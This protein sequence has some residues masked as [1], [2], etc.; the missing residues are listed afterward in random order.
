MST[1]VSN[2]VFDVNNIKECRIFDVFIPGQASHRSIKLATQAQWKNV[3]ATC[4]QS[5]QKRS[6][7]Q[8]PTEMNTKFILFHTNYDYR[9]RLSLIKACYHA[10]SCTILCYEL[11]TLLS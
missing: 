11:R 4:L 5:S 2:R 7:L 10:V 8:F 6:K 3:F 1:R 9:G